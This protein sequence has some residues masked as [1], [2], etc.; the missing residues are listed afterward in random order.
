MARTVFMGTHSPRLDDK[1]RIFL[2]AKFRDAL[3]E[4]VVVA[5]GQERCLY[6]WPRSGFRS[7]V[8]S[9]ELRDSSSRGRALQRSLYARS[10]DETLDRQGR[11]TLTPT[12]RDWAGLT[13]ECTVIG[14]G[15]RVEIWDAAAWET[16]SADQEAAFAEYSDEGSG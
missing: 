5:P 6:V 10:S 11:I 15:E 4:G 14:V 16:Y 7:Y 13:R 3:S 1:G 8:A 9:L 12:L 2:P